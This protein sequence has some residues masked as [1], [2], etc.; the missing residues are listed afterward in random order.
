VLLG[1]CS[2]SSPTT[3]DLSLLD[4]SQVD[5]GIVDAQV[6]AQVS[7]ILPDAGVEPISFTSDAICNASGWC[8]EHP[9]PQGNTLLD[10]WEGPNGS[11]FAVGV[12]G[13]VLRYKGLGWSRLETGSK[14]RL[15]GVWGSSP[16]DVFVVG[17]DYYAAKDRATVLRYD[18]TRWEKMSTASD[19]AL[20]D[21]W[22]SSS[23]DIWAVGSE[24]LHYDGVAWRSESDGPSLL[25]GVWG[26]ST[27]DVFAVGAMGA[28]WHYDGVS[29]QAME[30]PVKV[31]LQAIWGSGSDD[32]FAVGQLGTIVHYDGSRWSHQESHVAQSLVAI[33]GRSSSQVAAI[34]ED[35]VFVIYDGA[36][37]ARAPRLP[38]EGTIRSYALC[39][40]EGGDVVASQNHRLAHFDGDGWRV[41]EGGFRYLVDVW[42]SSPDDVY[43][44]AGYSTTSQALM[45]HYDGSTWQEMLWA[46]S[47]DFVAI[48]G[49]SAK[50]IFALTSSTVEIYDGST[51]R[52]EDLPIQGAHDIWG[53]S[54]SDLFVVGSAGAITHYDGTVWVSMT[55]PT[56]RSLE[57]VWGSS[58]TDV[59]AV[60]AGGVILHYDGSA[61]LLD[62]A[63]GGTRTHEAVWTSG[64]DDVWVAGYERILHYD[65]STWSETLIPNVDTIE[66]IW[67]RSPNDVYALS[68]NGNAIHYDGSSWV[69]EP[70]LA[71][72]DLYGLWGESD[73][74]L[75]AVGGNESIMR[76]S[77]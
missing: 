75:I 54:A 28:I 60:G 32:V 23:D 64:P 17:G 2:Q 67:G 55:S 25:R 19:A 31:N 47:P 49:L 21:V 48:W 9:Q 53:S 66:A 59:W 63:L 36:R 40:R 34:G 46:D 45:L 38:E 58:P 43:A 29:W 50:S 24:I 20:F 51:W 26:S 69:V 12:G 57:A 61:W 14:A 6:D 8:W 44:V 62:P 11:L 3:V 7:D 65:G 39:M 70:T 30:S 41:A 77:R 37:W 16:S 52:S 22:G 76:R 1:A 74:D 72:S 35:G 18:G 15:H 5:A 33:G 71:G 68:Q 27:D 10:F 4:G 13:T 42:G 73:G 56:T